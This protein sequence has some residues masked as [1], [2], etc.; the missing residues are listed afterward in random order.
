MEVDKPKLPEIKIQP[1][2]VN[3]KM[4]VIVSGFSSDIVASDFW[5]GIE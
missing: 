5:V 2:D 4:K 1:Q 3:F